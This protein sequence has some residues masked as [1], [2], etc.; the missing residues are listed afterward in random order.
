MRPLRRIVLESKYKV[1]LNMKLWYFWF[2]IWK[3]DMIVILVNMHKLY[4]YL[5]V[6]S[7]LNTQ[8]LLNWFAYKLADRPPQSYR[9]T[10][11]RNPRLASSGRP[12]GSRKPQTDSGV[13]R[14]KSRRGT[15]NRRTSSAAEKRRQG[16]RKESMAEKRRHDLKR[17]AEEDK[18]RAEEDKRREIQRILTID[19]P[20]EQVDR[21]LRMMDDKRYPEYSKVFL[22][23]CFKQYL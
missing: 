17:R 14:Q 21:F 2:L 13:R 8:A 7:Y 15:D 4:H 20:E 3:I 9:G 19:D 12:P 11:N 22:E 23:F 18:R 16:E 5:G 1:A 6:W 10:E